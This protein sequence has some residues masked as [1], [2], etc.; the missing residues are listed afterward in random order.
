MA[1]EEFGLLLFKGF[2]L[3]FIIFYAV[4]L[5]IKVAFKEIKEEKNI[6]SGEL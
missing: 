2:I 3:F 1:P 5:G 6:D 4:K